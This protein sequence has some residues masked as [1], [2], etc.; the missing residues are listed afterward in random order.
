M[1]EYIKE[2]ISETAKRYRK[3]HWGYIAKIYSKSEEEIY[4]KQAANLLYKKYSH[5]ISEEEIFDVLSKRGNIYTMYIINDQNA[6]YEFKTGNIMISHFLDRM[7]QT[8][9]H[10]MTHKLGFGRQNEEFNKMSVIFNEAGVEL[11]SAK[12]ID[13]KEKI[14]F[15]F[16]NASA[17][18]PNQISDS[19]ISV[20]LTTLSTKSDFALPFV[21]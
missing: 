15:L 5:I 17:K 21:E 4:Y 19:F 6:F 20:A 2:D 9:L 8:L 3:M 1:E 12:A 14:E 10:E 16:H 18:M 7:T 13:K 11:V